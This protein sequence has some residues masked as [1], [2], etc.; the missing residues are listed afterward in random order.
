MKGTLPDRWRDQTCNHGL[1]SVDNE[2]EVY[3]RAYG[4][5]SLQ[6]VLFLHGGPGSGVDLA[7]LCFFEPETHYVVMFDQRGASQSR[8]SGCV[9]N[10]TTHHLIADIELLRASL[11][12]P[13]WIVFGGSWGAT[14]GLLYGQ[15]YPD[16]CVGL[17][18][19]GISNS[20]AYQN[21][22][23]LNER[24][25]LMPD[26]HRV[27]MK[28]LNEEQQSNPVL[29]HYESIVSGD[30]IRQLEALNAINVLESGMS[31]AIT[32]S[33]ESCVEFTVSDLNG[34]L[35]NRAKIYLH[36]WAN[37]KFVNE[38]QCL[39]SP[40]A[41]RNIPVT[42]IHGESDWICPL[43]GAQEIVKALPQAKLISVPGAGHSPFHPNMKRA[44]SETLATLSV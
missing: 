18:L 26:R 43:S 27:F 25:K 28:R 2:H 41:L 30:V 31:E 14:L 15:N 38:T 36:Y 5:K 23:M 24:P 40:D 44:L 29:A 9:N 4:N 39:P 16:S 19:R 33:V 1:L 17:V 22:W 7:S 10:N 12:I 20:H 8:P 34:D 6:A 13:E 32:E 11:E 37:E 35:F 21:H 42:F 3:W